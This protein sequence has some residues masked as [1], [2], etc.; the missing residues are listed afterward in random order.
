MDSSEASMYKGVSKMVRKNGVNSPLL[1]NAND[2]GD[3]SSVS[4]IIF[5][6]E[7]EGEIFPKN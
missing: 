6:M 1:A 5:K 4:I 3:F 2:Q 7:I